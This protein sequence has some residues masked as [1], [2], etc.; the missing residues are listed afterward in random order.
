MGAVEDRK[1]RHAG[2]AVAPAAVTPAGAAVGLQVAVFAV[3]ADIAAAVAGLPEAV[4]RRS[5]SRASRAN[6]LD[7][8]DHRKERTGATTEAI[9][10]AGNKRIGKTSLER[11]GKIG[12]ISLGT[13]TMIVATGVTVM[14]A[15]SG[16]GLLLV[17]S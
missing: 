9:H 14:A 13:F 15:M 16:P 8:L 12:R 4:H 11:H 17:W 3:R 10:V 2:P 6:K 1:V 5:D 7:R